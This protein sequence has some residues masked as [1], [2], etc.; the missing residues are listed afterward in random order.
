[1]KTLIIP[2]AEGRVLPFY[3]AAEE[4]VARNLDGAD[5]WFFA[6]Q[7]EPTVICGRH[8]E[9]PLEVDMDYARDYGI[10]VWRRK[11]GG[12]CVYAD[13][14]NVMFSYIT[15]DRGG[16][17]GCFTRYT[18]LVCGMLASL[19]I[20]ARPTG[21]N[22]IAVDGHKVAGNAFYRSHGRSIVHGTMLY[23]ADPD[24][25]GRVLTPS[26]AKL[27]SKSVV[28]V[29]ARITTLRRCGIAISCDDFIR[30]AVTLLGSNGSY[31]LAPADVAAVEE[32]MQE[33][34]QPGFLRREGVGMRAPGASRRIEGVGELSV[35]VDI[36]PGGII[37][38]CAVGGDFFGSRDALERMCAALRGVSAER[39]PLT[40]V[41]GGFLPGDAV[42]GLDA[43]T[44]AGLIIEATKHTIP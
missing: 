14:H 39:D 6:W 19:G 42:E 23:D 21:R 28:S 10:Q 11:S 34:L 32:I 13:S 26:R 43:A 9:M 31:T 44:M 16:V 15:A 1:M 18:G 30:R 7:V 3:L 17:Q 40:G 37:A 8:Q 4:W 27:M 12:G 24:T 36:A 38:R 22:D 20:D 2:P 5:D 35:S 33:Y 29:P 41:L 25:M